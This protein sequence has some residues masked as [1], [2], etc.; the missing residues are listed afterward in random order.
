MRAQVIAMGQ[1]R[2][3]YHKL[4]GRWGAGVVW[5]W[6]GAALRREPPLYCSE[7]DCPEGEPADECQ[8]C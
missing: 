2:V 1:D 8:K 4:W 5:T 6:D 7:K 3:A